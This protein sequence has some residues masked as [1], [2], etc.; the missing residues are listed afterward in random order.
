MGRIGKNGYVIPV[1]K[2]IVP[3]WGIKLT[4]AK[5]CLTG[6]PGYIGWQD[7]SG[8]TNPMLGR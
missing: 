7:G 6:P 8:T 3:D 4:L 2:I 1:A 5:V